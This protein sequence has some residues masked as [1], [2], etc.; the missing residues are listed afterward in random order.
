MV[1]KAWYCRREAMTTLIS[2]G[3][4]T[5][6]ST[7]YSLILCTV[8]VELKHYVHTGF[9]GQTWLMS[10]TF[11]SLLVWLVSITHNNI[12]KQE[13]FHNV[14]THRVWKRLFAEKWLFSLHN[15]KKNME[16]LLCFLFLLVY[17]GRVSFCKACNN[18]RDS[19]GT[20]FSSY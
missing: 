3:V 10:K 12:C 4:C 20:F 17:S 7:S 9:V 13:L 8:H 6:H 14:T 19:S 18:G 5:Y 2:S 15:F 16:L 1:P 11:F